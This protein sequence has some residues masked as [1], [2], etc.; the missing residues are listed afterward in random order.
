VQTLAVTAVAGL[1]LVGLVALAVTFGV[2]VRLT[3]GQQVVLAREEATEAAQSL[4]AQLG[5]G[6]TL[7]SAQA[8]QG[9]F[10]DERIVVQDSGG[11][12][13]LGGRLSGRT[14]TVTSAGTGGTVTVTAPVEPET[15]FSLALT[16][17]TAGVL[18]LVGLAAAVVTWRGT[19]R[20]RHTL[21]QASSAAERLSAGDLSVRLA[22]GGPAES[23]ALGHALNSMAARLADTDLEQRQ[24]LTDLAHEIATPYQIVA[25]LAQALADGTIAGSDDLDAGDVVAQETTRMARLL[26]D[27]RAL[28]RPDL[29]PELVPTDLGALASSLVDRF[30]TLAATNQIRLRSRVEHLNLSTDPH[31]VE[32]VVSNFVTNALRATP[33]GGQVVVDVRRARGRALLSVTDTGPGIAPQEQERIFDRFYRLDR[34]R[35]RAAGGAGLGLSIARRYAHA[36]GGWIELDSTV[37]RG[38]RFTLIL[39]TQPG[40]EPT[41]QPLA[42]ASAPSPAS[43]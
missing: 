41:T 25:G 40:R 3:G 5:H 26:D 37:G 35:D 9:F 2:F 32:T 18:L 39:P 23:A 33:A 36:L 1:V 8:Q 22:E 13:T 12:F 20:V 17:I 16:G 29:T 10:A 43:P 38:S 24:F 31:L 14:V 11:S 7:A 27:L 6:L 34:A 42:T 19:G 30:T 21:E 15:A 28:T 4:A